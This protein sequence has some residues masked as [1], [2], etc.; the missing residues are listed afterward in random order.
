M[1]AR[2]TRT[3]AAVGIMMVAMLVL[4]GC[5]TLGSPSNNTPAQATMQTGQWEFTVA[6]SNGNPN[7]YVESDVL[8]GGTPGGNPSAGLGSYIYE[9][10]L[11]WPQTGGSIAGS[12]EYF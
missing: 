12:Y 7:I 8:H 2:R 9:T 1:R 10:A 11:F 3:K 5:G 6:S 4:V